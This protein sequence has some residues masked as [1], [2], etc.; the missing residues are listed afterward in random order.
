MFIVLFSCDR[1]RHGPEP[2]Y[3]LS[4]LCIVEMF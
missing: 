4:L 3:E 2:Y 1:T